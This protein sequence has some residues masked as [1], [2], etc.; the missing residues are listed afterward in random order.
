MSEEAS[1]TADPKMIILDIGKKKR[2]Q[3]R[4]L[5]KGRGRLAARIEAAIED[6]TADGRIAEGAQTVVMIVEKKRRKN[7][8]LRV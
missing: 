7:R 6:L 5:R 4:R 1:G 8:W 2:K 3:V